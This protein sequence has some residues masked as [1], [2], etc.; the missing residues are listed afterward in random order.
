MRYT[1]SP[2]F[3]GLRPFAADI[4]EHF[5]EG[6]TTL[7]SGRNTLKAFHI[8]GHDLVVKSFKVPNLT[9]RFAYGYMRPS[10]AERS[11]GN[12]LR[13]K[14]LGIG[15][16]E[17]VGYAEY[18]SAGLLLQSYYLSL[19]LPEA[20]EIRA[21]FGD[22]DFPQREEILREFAAFTW[23]LH[24][25]RILHIDYSAGNILITEK[26]GKRRFSLVDLNRVRFA[27]IPPRTALRSLS[28]LGAGPE[29]AEAIARHYAKEAGLDPRWASETLRR[30][31]QA[32]L[33]K[34]ALKNRLR[35]P[36]RRWRK[37]GGN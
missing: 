20:C 34:L 7:F 16:P 18:T 2:A 30:D 23:Q 12:A 22:P 21:V 32:H 1:L 26:E 10:K 24:R 14:A 19:A 25:K 3:A 35:A 33:N 4:R 36:L 27:G 11:Y 31:R 13:L 9:N 15:T 8:E 17:P 37:R 29:D 5:R 28:R 6:G